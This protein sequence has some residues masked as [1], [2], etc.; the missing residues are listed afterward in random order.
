MIVLNCSNNCIPGTFGGASS[1]QYCPAGKTSNS[2]DAMSCDLCPSGSYSSIGDLSCSVCPTGSYTSS[3]GS[4]ACQLCPPGQFSN[5]TN[6]TVCFNCPNG[7]ATFF[8]GAISSADCLFCATKP[9]YGRTESGAC[10]PCPAGKYSINASCVDCAPGKFSNNP[11]RESCEYCYKGT[12]ASNSSQSSCSQCQSGSLTTSFGSTSSADCFFCQKGKFSSINLT[13]Q[14]AYCENCPQ[15]KW[16]SNSGM[17]SLSECIQCPQSD[18]TICYAGSSAPFVFAGWFRT[19]ESGLTVVRRC[20]PTEACPQAGF[21]DTK[22][23]TGYSGVACSNCAT[24]YFR[25]GDS[26]KKCV[27]AA[28]QWTIYFALFL[29]IILVLWKLS[30]VQGRIPYV[31]KLTFNWIQMLSLYG[32]LTDRWPSTLKAIFNVSSVLNL[33]LEYFGFTC[34]TGMNFW[35]LWYLKLCLPLIIFFSVML[36]MLF[37]EKKHISSFIDAFRVAKSKLGIL[38][39]LLTLFSTLI[40][41]TIFQVFNCIP[42]S[43]SSYVLRADPSIFCYTSSWKTSVYGGIFF[44]FLYCFILPLS[45]V[46]VIIKYRKSREDLLRLMNPFVSPYSEGCEYWEFVKLFWKLVFIILRDTSQLD[47]LT[48][49]IILGAALVGEHWFEIEMSPYA[50]RTVGRVSAT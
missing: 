30:S 39:F 40:F 1:C 43:D 19:N 23:T 41:S 2:I 17:S 24:G 27:P 9:G 50:S 46:A 36:I 32:V 35:K 38:S 45:G 47:S 6:S 20:Y 15:G 42:Q 31:W 33:Q 26:C 34:N 37:R 18:G 4:S 22:C 13:N 5:T 3:P 12:Y 21:E 16:S 44:M 8:E 25:S 29:V 14:D 28:V 11:A 10:I 48:K 7:T 49:T